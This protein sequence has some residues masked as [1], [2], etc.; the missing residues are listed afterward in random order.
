MLLLD[1]IR[2]SN[3]LSYRTFIDAFPDLINVVE[4]VHFQD[5]RSAIP[6]I[7]LLVLSILLRYHGLRVVGW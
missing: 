6:V 2:K 5:R 1:A 3:L 7:V 4:I